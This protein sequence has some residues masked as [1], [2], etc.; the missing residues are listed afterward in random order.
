MVPS[1]P[2]AS[3]AIMPAE[4]GSHVAFRLWRAHGSAAQV[5]TCVAVVRA[6]HGSAATRP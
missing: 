5:D 6:K 4:A 1:I 2:V 3:P